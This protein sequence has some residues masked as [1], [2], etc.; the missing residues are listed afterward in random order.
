MTDDLRARLD[1]IRSRGCIAFREQ[2]SN[3]E[4][5]QILVVELEAHLEEARKDLHSSRYAASGMLVGAIIEA[6]R[7]LSS[8]GDGVEAVARVELAIIKELERQR[9]ADVDEFTPRV[10]DM[11]DYAVIDGPIDIKAIARAALATLPGG[12]EMRE[13]A[14]TAVERYAEIAR[15]QGLDNTLVLLAAHVV[16][17]TPL[18]HEPA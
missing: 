9:D 14:A 15:E 16:R 6:A 8:E 2:P 18:P 7:R 13:A 12:A 10:V 11:I 1:A 3:A 4:L 17:C 5:V